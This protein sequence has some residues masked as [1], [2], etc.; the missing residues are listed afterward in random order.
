MAHSLA[1]DETLSGASFTNDRPGGRP[2]DAEFRE[3]LSTYRGFVKGV[4]LFAGHALAILI[5]LYYFLM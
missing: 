1:H 3:H 5:L 2:A 4:M